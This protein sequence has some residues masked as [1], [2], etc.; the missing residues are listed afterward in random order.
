MN[1]LERQQGLAAGFTL[2]PG[3]F[4]TVILCAAL[5][6]GQQSAR[7]TNIK[8]TFEAAQQALQAGRFV[9]A[10]AGFREVLRL[11]PRSAA[12]YANLGVVYLRMER[13]PAA[14]KALDQAAQLAPQVAGIQ[15]NLGLAYIRQSQFQ[16]A[17]PHFRRALELTPQQDQA[18]YLLGLSQYMVGDCAGVGKRHSPL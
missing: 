18:R 9:A 7:P 5:L 10:E 6:P 16:Q 4:L 13:F 14:I 3:A 8:E 11:D 12:A 2:L 17:I 15:L 1:R